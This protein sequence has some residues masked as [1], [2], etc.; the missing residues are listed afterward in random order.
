[1]LQTM[2]KGLACSTDVLFSQM[3]SAKLM[4]RQALLVAT[5]LRLQARMRGSGCTPWESRGCCWAA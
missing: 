3:T 1:M 2:M 5:L 4:F